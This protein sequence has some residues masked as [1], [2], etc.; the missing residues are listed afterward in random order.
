MFAIIQH[1]V[2]PEN[3]VTAD[4]SEHWGKAFCPVCLCVT[5]YSLL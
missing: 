1:A 4:V 5:I 3:P 2:M